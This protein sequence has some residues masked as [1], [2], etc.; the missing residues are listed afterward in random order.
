[1]IINASSCQKVATIILIMIM[2]EGGHGHG[3]CMRMQ[4]LKRQVP[5]CTQV[6]RQVVGGVDSLS[7]ARTNYN[8]SNRTRD[9]KPNKFLKIQP[10]T[11]TKSKQLITHNYDG[12]RQKFILTTYPT[13][14]K[15]ETMEEKE[16]KKNQPFK[17]IR[18]PRVIKL[19]T[20]GLQQH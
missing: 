15:K 6:Y 1:M 11:Y 3:I 8:G 13:R 19:N 17:E 12:F 20:N 7:Q 9:L 5:T 16:K 14:N 10:T 4:Y 18:G 2:I